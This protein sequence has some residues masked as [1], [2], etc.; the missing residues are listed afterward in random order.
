MSWHYSQA[1][2]EECLEQGCLDSEQYAQLKSNRT[3]LKQAV[4]AKKKGILSRSG[5]GTTS[6][7]SMVQRGVEKWISLLP[8]SPAS[9]S[10]RPVSEPD[11]ETTGTC[12]RIR[13]VSFAKLDPPL[14]GSRTCPDSSQRTWVTNQK[15]LFTTTLEPYCETWRKAGMMRDGVCY[16][17]PSAE[18]PISEQGSGLLLPTPT[19]SD[20]IDVIRPVRM[21][22][23]SPRIVSN[24]GVDGQAK[25][26]EAVAHYTKEKMW[27]GGKQTPQTYPTPR[28]QDGEK[29]GQ[30]SLG[31]KQEGGALN[32]DWVEWLMGW[33]IGWTALEPL[34]T[35]RFRKWLELHGI[36]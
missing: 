10:P 33:P 30:G 23:R 32:P 8:D 34:A 36:S 6:E 26:S 24:Q 25:L 2:L 4:D 20:Y 12:G 16:L 19:K 29:M 15:E 14:S 31:E 7:P 28:A 22:G 9:H 35:D 3:A 18:R 17:Q 5:Y 21:A 11:P 13:Y 1:V 27:D